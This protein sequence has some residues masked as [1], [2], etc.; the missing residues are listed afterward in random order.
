MRWNDADVAGAHVDELDLARG[1]AWEGQHFVRQRAEA[2]DV[3]RRLVHGNQ[4]GRLFEA[5]EADAVLEDDGYS[6]PRQL[7][8]PHRGEGGYLYR[9]L[10]GQV[11]PDDGLL[12][13]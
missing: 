10:A 9:N 5:V 11:I 7:N 13:G 4:V 8:A 6:A 2:H 3:V 12:Q 1:P